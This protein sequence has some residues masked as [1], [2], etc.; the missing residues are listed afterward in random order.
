MSSFVLSKCGET[1][2]R[3]ALLVTK[4]EKSFCSLFATSILSNS[5]GNR[6][7]I[8]ALRSDSDRG[9]AISIPSSLTP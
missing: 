7:L 9:E 3:P 1:L 4:I 6:R 2:S 5:S 8:I